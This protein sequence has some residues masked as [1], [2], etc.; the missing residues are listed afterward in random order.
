MTPGLKKEI[1]PLLLPWGVALVAALLL[2]IL[3]THRN[4]LHQA[5]LRSLPAEWFETMAWLAVFVGCMALAAM[6]FGV[7]LHHRTVGLILVQPVER[8]RLWW[9]KMLPLG[10]AFISVGLAYI[11]G[12]CLAD[13]NGGTTPHVVAYRGTSNYGVQGDSF[14]ALA[15]L[16]GILCS[17]AFWTLLSRSIIGGMVLPVAAQALLAGIITY[18]MTDRTMDVAEEQE[19][20]LFLALAIGAVVYCL[21]FAYLGWWKFARLEWREASAGG[22]LVA[23]LEGRRP[24]G[25]DSSRRRLQGRTS[26]PWRSLLRKEFRLQRAVFLLAALFVVC[27]F[28]AL[29]L[30]WLRPAWHDYFEGI[31]GVMLAVYLPLV[32]LLAG[33]ISLGEEKNLGTWGWHLTLPFSVARQWAAKVFVAVLVVLGLGLLLPGLAALIAYGFKVDRPDRWVTEASPVLLVA[34]YTTMLSFWAVTMLGTAIR[35]VLFTLVGAGTL[36]FGSLF[37]LGIGAETHIQ[38]G[39]CT[40]IMVTYQ[41]NPHHFASNDPNIMGAVVGTSILLV[42]LLRQSYVHCR[43]EPSRAVIFKCSLVLMVSLFLPLWWGADLTNSFQSLRSS[44]PVQHLLAAVR[45]LP[46]VT[47]GDVPSEPMQ[48]TV[49]Q[50]AQTGMLDAETARWLRNARIHIVRPVFANSTRKQPFIQVGVTFR[51][52]QYFETAIDLR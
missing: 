10:G 11:V 46:A 48:V 45:Q 44:P 1:R 50:L 8:I 7:E 22:T 3:P 21:A 26:G 28:A 38:I 36:F 25:N 47:R 16:L 9:A 49:E 52:G 34:G 31:L 42:L 15:L 37:L 40:W 13:A 24:R 20:G 29:G 41:F 19:P 14:V 39:L 32:W 18:L 43:R 12:L 6:S 33:C 27:W 17:S 23:A 4:T 5:F 51:K 30:R 2:P 35:A